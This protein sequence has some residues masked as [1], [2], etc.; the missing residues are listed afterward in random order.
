MVKDFF[1][2]EMGNAA[3]II[4]ILIV[5]AAGIFLPWEIAI[6]I[7]TLFFFFIGGLC[8]WNYSTCKRVHCQITGI[9]FTAVG[10]IALLNLLS[11]INLNWG[12]IW[13]I[14]FLILIIGYGYEFIYCKKTGSCYKK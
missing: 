5:I 2:S 9:G 6:I 1:S 4:S 13:G 7:F 8:L 12:I 3:T 14:Y 11:I 10:I